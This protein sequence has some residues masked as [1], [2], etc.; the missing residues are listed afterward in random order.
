[1][2]FIPRKHYEKDWIIYLECTKCWEFKNISSFVTFTKSKAFMNKGS[3]CKECRTEYRK[4]NR[5][6]HH[7]YI[8]QYNIDNR[9]RLIRHKREYNKNHAKELA[10][11]YVERKTRMWYWPLHKKTTYTIA[12]LWIRPKICPICNKDVYNIQ[13]HHPDNNVWNEIVFCC[14]SCH[15][16]IHNGFIKCPEPIDL[17]T[18]QK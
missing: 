1:M 10:I 18:Y 9:D 6:K 2:R 17:L 14:Q 13:A 15:S 8:M 16:A 4:I 7:E 12:K 5:D 11:K 3:Y